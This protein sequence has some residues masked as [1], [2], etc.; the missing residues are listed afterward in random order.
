M[1]TKISYCMAVLQVFKS[2]AAFPALI[3]EGSK[4]P[5]VQALTCVHIELDDD[6]PLQAPAAAT[7]KAWAMVACWAPVQLVPA[8]QACSEVN[9]SLPPAKLLRLSKTVAALI[10]PARSCSP[11]EPLAC[12]VVTKVAAV[13]MSEPEACGPGFAK[14]KTGKA[15]ILP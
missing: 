2:A 1:L 9:A 10:R 6:D 3:V 12:A 11:E 7:T 5:P 15:P 8:A 13:V 14:I 4:L